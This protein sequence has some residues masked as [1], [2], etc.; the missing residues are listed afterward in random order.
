LLAALVCAAAGGSSPEQIRLAL[1][2]KPDE[3][4]VG[5][6][7][8][9][10]TKSTVV[11]YTCPGCASQQTLGTASRY[12]LPWIPIYRS[13]QIHF[14]RLSGLKSNTTYSYR[15]GDGVTWSDTHTFTTIA[16]D[17]GTPNNPLRV[18]SIGDQGATPDSKMVLDA[19]I[20]AD[21]KLN[22]HALVHAGDISY[23]NGRQEIWDV[24]GRMVQPLSD[25]V[26]WM[27]SVGNHEL[28]D[29][30]EPFLKRFAMPAKESGASYG[31]LYYSFDLGPVH[32]IILDSESF[33]YFHMSP[34]Y[35]W[36]ENDLRSVNRTKTPWI[37]SS[38]HGPW[39]CSNT[40]H[41]YDE[42]LM[43]ES[44]EDIF[45]KYKVDLLLLGA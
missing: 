9:D 12:W 31:N 37:I 8:V 35:K 18:L 29:L 2:G 19:M 23:A 7:T 22:F 26:P 3:V 27:V 32:F 45:Y 20:A 41:R 34:Q 25:H 11:Q 13:P 4:V 39:Y 17:I 40:V 36:L 44:F 43:R 5:W 1:T 6:A 16:D 38:W 24:W 14:V 21:K 42:Y 10:D 15:V 33:Q 30:L 28:L